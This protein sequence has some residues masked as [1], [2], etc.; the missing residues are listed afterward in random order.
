VTISDK[1]LIFWSWNDALE[2]P[3][4]LRQLSEFHANGLG[5]CF[6]HARAGLRTPYMSEEWMACCDAVCEHAAKLGF[7][8]YLYDED[9]WPSGF[10]GGI[11]P[12]MGEDF[13]QK[14]VHV[15]KKSPDSDCVCLAAYAQN[16]DD[17]TL[18]W[19]H[20]DSTPCPKA[21]LYAFCKTNRH[22][23]DLTYPPAV[24]CFLQ[25]VHEMY[26][27]RLGKYFG[28]VIR[29]IFTDEP[30]LSTCGFHWAPHIERL[31]TEEYGSDLLT[32]MWHLA[33]DG[34]DVGLSKRIRYR[35]RRLIQQQFENVF[36]RRIGEWCANRN[37][38]LTG[39]FAA[40]DGLIMQLEA[41]GSVMPHYRHFQMP[42]IDH[43]GRRYAPLPLL[44]QVQSVGAQTGKTHLLSETFGCSGWN[45]SFE[46]VTRIWGWQAINGLTTPCLHLAAYSLAGRRK[47]DYPPSFSYQAPWWE[48]C[49]DITGWLENVC[50][51]FQSAR[52]QVNVLIL[53]P[54]RDLW[55]KFTPETTLEHLPQSA[56]FRS[57]VEN[58]RY[59]GLDFD[60]GE[61]S[62]LE[63][64]GSISDDR[65][66]VGE[67]SYELVVVPPCDYLEPKTVS[68]LKDFVAVGGRVL[69]V[70]KRPAVNDLPFG[71][72]A[73]NHHHWLRKLF[74]NWHWPFVVDI[75]VADGHVVGGVST[76]YGV[77]ND[78]TATQLA[79]YP[80]EE[81]FGN[82]A[83][84]LWING[85]YSPTLINPLTRKEQPLNF[86]V[87]G[88][89]T[90]IRATL[91]YR[92]LL[93]LVLHPADTEKFLIA[94]ITCT[95][96]ALKP[97][98]IART[99]LNALTLDTAEI[100]LDGI[101]F[102]EPLP[103]PTLRKT[104][105]TLRPNQA[106]VYLRWTFQSELKNAT[107]LSLALETDA[108]KE[109]WCNGN[110]LSVPTKDAPYFCDRA[111]RLVPLTE[112]AHQGENVL[113]CRY[114]RQVT[115]RQLKADFESESNR[116]CPQ[117][118]P[119]SV[120]LYG[121]F[122]VCAQGVINT[123]A[124]H[125]TVQLPQDQ[126]PCFVLKPSQPLS[127]GDLTEQGLW[128]Y[129]GAVKYA[130]T[131]EPVLG[132]TA[133]LRTGKLNGVT[134]TVSV[135]GGEPKPIFTDGDLTPLQ[136][137]F[138]NAQNEITVT[139]YGSNRNLLGPHHHQSG[140]P[141]FVGFDTFEGVRSWTDGF[142]TSIATTS[143][144][145]DDY[146]FVPFGLDS[147]ALLLQEP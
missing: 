145:D 85:H 41:N 36:S 143:T 92:Q 64:M 44:K 7:D 83:V 80:A 84:E 104:V 34:A 55:Q 72:L 130:F 39:H 13:C 1:P 139:V 61:E 128:F 140:E 14:I 69:Y 5:G 63:Q 131:C 129:R 4:L 53:Q 28:T 71:E 90:C 51:Y 109:I 56:A 24:D 100:S 116:Y 45:L 125:I 60:L 21:D 98:E 12:S 102:S 57:L 115:E 3:E 133:W 132:R 105:A 32:D 40:E 122:Q 8:I 75:R 38:I 141:L 73:C 93:L 117:W 19:R 135:N 6:L 86:T 18:I 127:M 107:L 134:A 106:D 74:L 58:L 114:S 112:Y 89:K 99:A 49:K 78:N 138:D 22:Y 66:K 91:N 142:D 81:G 26:A 96:R 48:R 33:Y 59:I 17:Y 120:Y 29:G 67:S 77:S 82:Q 62:F 54:L 79:L 137:L 27:A 95:E 10:A 136:D 23:A 108:L 11:V 97:Q 126:R 9:G 47:R 70:D 88:D 103:L 42:G 101:T 146:S 35:Y 124:N 144:W 31:Y 87:S 50:H 123:F 46:D 121:D 20:T 65:L 15:A 30:Q 94:P 76:W 68:L 118:E 37:L 113:V 119:E 111:F 110:V 2:I 43:L 147:C 52:R 16:G 25:N